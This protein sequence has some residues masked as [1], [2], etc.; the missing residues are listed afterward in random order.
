MKI[1]CFLTG[2]G[3]AVKEAAGEYDPQKPLGEY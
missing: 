2:A 3:A 1:Y